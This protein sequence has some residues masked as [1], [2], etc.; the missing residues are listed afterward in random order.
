[1]ST[2]QTPSPLLELFLSDTLE[3]AGALRSGLGSL[4]E[5]ISRQA[6]LLPQLVLSAHS[7]RGA[8]KIVGFEPAALI[9]TAIISGLCGVRL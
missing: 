5:D 6:S 7:I 3:H 4:A 8:A 2:P 1:M 9:A